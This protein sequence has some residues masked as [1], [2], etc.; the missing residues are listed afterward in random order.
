MRF[1]LLFWWWFVSSIETSSTLFFRYYKLHLGNLHMSQHK[2]WLHLRWF[3][4]I[5][6]K[7]FRTL[8]VWIRREKINTLHTLKYMANPPSIS[9]LFI[10]SLSISQIF[11]QI[12]T[13]PLYHFLIFFI[14]FKSVDEV[15]IKSLKYCLLLI[16]QETLI[17]GRG[18]KASMVA[19]SWS[20]EFGLCYAAVH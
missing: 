2:K 10:K 20:L 5:D 8:G 7:P 9:R 3:M 14:S 16:S 13:F 6:L 11:L 15:V 19:K 1:F 12:P 17:D 18:K 4:S